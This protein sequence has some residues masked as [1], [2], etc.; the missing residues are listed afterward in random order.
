MFWLDLDLS[1]FALFPGAIGDEVESYNCA[2]IIGD[3][4]TT[5]ITIFRLRDCALACSSLVFLPVGV[6]F[7]SFDCLSETQVK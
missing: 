6:S 7:S 4:R 5:K 1:W 3:Y 2:E